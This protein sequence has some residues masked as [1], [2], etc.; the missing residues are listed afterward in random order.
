MNSNDL[1]LFLD[2]AFGLKSQKSSSSQ[3]ADESMHYLKTPSGIFAHFGAFRETITPSRTSPQPE[4]VLFKLVT[5]GEICIKSRT[6]E[7]WLSEGTLSLLPWS[8]QFEESFSEPT[9]LFVIG[10]GQGACQSLLP[11]LKKNGGVTTQLETPDLQYLT[12]LI[13]QY[14]FHADRISSGL[15]VTSSQMII[16]T[17]GEVL[18]NSR[19]TTT[20]RLTS[21]VQNIAAIKRFIAA[22][23]HDAS[24][25]AEMISENIRLSVNYMNRLLAE[26]N[27]SLMKLVWQQRLEAAKKLLLKPGMR[28]MQLAEIAWL[29]GFTSQSHFSQAFKKKFGITPREMRDLNP[30]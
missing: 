22:N 28:T 26:E 16:A 15:S 24:L 7:L 13:N 9:S 8:S 25:D 23:L 10:C 30:L 19:Q 2:N 3:C 11:I 14:I 18:I 1:S 6:R 20:S 21:K 5:Q 4:Q 29:C 27:L 17:L 12:R